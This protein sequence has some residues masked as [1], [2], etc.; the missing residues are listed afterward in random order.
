MNELGAVLGE[1]WRR[2]WPNPVLWGLPLILFLGF[3]LGSLLL[4][5]M[6]YRLAG[7]GVLLI[8]LEICAYGAMALSAMTGAWASAARTGRATSDEATRGISRY[9]WRMTGLTGLVLATA[10]AAGLVFGLVFVTATFGQMAGGTFDPTSFS[11][12]TAG[13]QLMG[14]A[15]SLGLLLLYGFA[16][17][18]IGLENTTTMNGVG[19]GLSFVGRRFGLVAG[20]LVVGLI[21]YNGPSYLLALPYLKAFGAFPTDPSS[22]TEADAYALLGLVGRMIP[23]M[24]LMIALACVIGSFVALS[25]FVAFERN[26]GVLWPPAVTADSAGPGA[27]PAVEVTGSPAGGPPDIDNK[28]R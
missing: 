8:F 10:L 12:N 18:S 24:L 16:P 26:R 17:A 2:F 13:S 22:F 5:M 14:L 19:R 6:L 28:N 20:L 3:V 15:V 23:V 25:L 4:W 1:T 27:G 9:F 7:L 21:I 11:G